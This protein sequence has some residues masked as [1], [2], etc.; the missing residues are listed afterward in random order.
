MF[1]VFRTKQKRHLSIRNAAAKQSNWDRKKEGFWR[2][3]LAVGLLWWGFFHSLCQCMSLLSAILPAKALNIKQIAASTLFTVIVIVFGNRDCRF[4][5]LY[6]CLITITSSRLTSWNHCRS[7]WDSW[8]WKTS[9]WRDPTPH[10]IFINS[11][12]N[13]ENSWN[14]PTS[15][16][17]PS[18]PPHHPH[19][20]SWCCWPET[21]T[22]SLEVKV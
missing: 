22:A 8:T 20:W 13:W 14:L 19:H 2:E 18:S 21:A 6:T 1:M 10:G 16:N 11:T 3:Q 15:S 5:D 12:W 7:F 17:L 4:F 9:S